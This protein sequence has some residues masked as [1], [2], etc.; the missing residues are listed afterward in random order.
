MN[1]IATTNKDLSFQY[2]WGEEYTNDAGIRQ[3]T[4]VNVIRK[5]DELSFLVEIDL[6]GEKVTATILEE[7]LFIHD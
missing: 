3:G 1:K 5:E 2:L 4:T 6:N 7:D